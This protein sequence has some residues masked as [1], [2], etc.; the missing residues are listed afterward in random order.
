[1]NQHALL[2]IAAVPEHF[3]LPWRL[4]VESGIFEQHHLRVEYQE[5]P[6]G[7]GA[8]T[9]ALRE[10]QIDVAIGLTEGLVA[11]ILRGN[12]GKIVKVFVE[13]PLNWGV[14]V[15]VNSSIASLADIHSA[16]YAISRPGSGSH[17]MAIVEAVQQGFDP[18]GLTFQEVGHLH[19]ALDSMARGESEVFFWERFMT[20]PFVDSG[21]LRR[22][23]VVLTPWP[24]FS[25]A[26]HEHLLPEQA[27]ALR[28]ALELVHEQ[29]RLLKARPDAA[30]LL[31]TR[32]QLKE[33]QVSE[34]LSLTTWSQDFE[35]PEKM[36]EAVQVSLVQAKIVP[37]VVPAASLIF[38]L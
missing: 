25:V 24:C 28:L 37:K 29:I 36:I 32:Y 15:P 9:R 6:G 38:S 21:Q 16:I 1:M 18:A 23:G 27:G 14:H 5:V 8:M 30:S 26:A 12:P 34:W 35:V 22:V 2:R 11:D 4:A 13:S 20:Q 3:N 10:G 17:L 31:A 33:D 7:T 19:G